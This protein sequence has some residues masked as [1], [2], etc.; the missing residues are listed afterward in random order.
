MPPTPPSSGASSHPLSSWGPP[1]P[2]DPGSAQLALGLKLPSRSCIHPV[3]EAC[4][5]WALP[6]FC[7][8]VRTGCPLPRPALCTLP[9]PPAPKIGRPLFPSLAG[10]EARRQEEACRQAA[11]APPSASPGATGAWNSLPTAARDACAPRWRESGWSAEG[12]PC[13]GH[14]PGDRTATPCRTPGLGQPVLT[15]QQ[16]GVS[17]TGPWLA[18]WGEKFTRVE[19]NRTSWATD[20]GQDPFLSIPGE[21]PPESEVLGFGPASAWSL[22]TSFPWPL[23]PVRE[24]GVGSCEGRPP[25]PGRALGTLAR[26]Q[27][28]SRNRN[29][30]RC[31]CDPSGYLLSPGCSG[32]ASCALSTGGAPGAISSTRKKSRRQDPCGDGAPC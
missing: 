11:V 24:M 18:A 19:M 30:S 32:L 8:S 4:G 25:A 17:A 12:Q 13:P 29:S 1:G 3:S 2:T 26:T 27:Q 22:C 14:V 5:F 28:H 20:V 21:G 16:T 10:T 6:D 23:P 15:E 9:P 31:G 7:A